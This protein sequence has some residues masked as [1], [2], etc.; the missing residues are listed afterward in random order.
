MMGERRGTG[1][2]V[3]FGSALALS[4]MIGGLAPSRAQACGG[5][6]APMGPTGTPTTVDAHRMVIAV[7][8][9]R[10]VL[11]DQIVYEGS[12]SDFVWVLPVAPGTVV[13]LSDNTFFEGLT[14]TTQITA[15]S[16][17][18]RCVRSWRSMRRST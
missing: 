6:F 8:P 13:E 5:C 17:T 1:A 2:C 9:G 18:T 12:P 16:S 7:G 3:A 4:A 11:W 10:T 14:A 15:T